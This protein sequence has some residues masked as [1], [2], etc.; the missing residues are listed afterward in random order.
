MVRKYPTENDDDKSPPTFPY[1]SVGDNC[2]ITN[3]RQ[4]A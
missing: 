2:L 1:I 3:G 4:V